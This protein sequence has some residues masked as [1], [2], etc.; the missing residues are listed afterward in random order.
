MTIFEDSFD[1]MFNKTEYRIGLFKDFL[2]NF[3]KVLFR[4]SIFYTILLLLG[5]SL[6][7]YFKTDES[8]ITYIYM[9][10]LFSIIL[11]VVHT[12]IYNYQWINITNIVTQI[13][14]FLSST[15]LLVIILNQIPDIYE[16]IDNVRIVNS[17]DIVV[18]YINPDE[19]YSINK[20]KIVDLNDFIKNVEVYKCVTFDNWNRHVITETKLKYKDEYTFGD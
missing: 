20:D 2:K 5:I 19:V 6:F 10:G 18:I 13:T 7:I 15:V 11:A 1:D 17:T 16:K 4:L 12:N 8:V 3:Y 9:F 14:I